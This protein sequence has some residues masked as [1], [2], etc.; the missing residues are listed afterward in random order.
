MAALAGIQAN[1]LLSAGR[2]RQVA[3]CKDGID[4]DSGQS[5]RYTRNVA[6]ACQS[7][8]CNA[9]TSSSIQ[10]Y[11]KVVGTSQKWPAKAGGRSPKGP[12]VAGTTVHIDST[13]EITGQLCNCSHN[14]DT[15]GSYQPFHDQIG[16]GLT[17]T[18]Q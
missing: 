6:F 11:G 18:G 10:F 4:P 8:Q 7:E 5:S 13:K 16:H 1:I 2:V 3:V 15:V 12:A 17:I 14:N 9:S